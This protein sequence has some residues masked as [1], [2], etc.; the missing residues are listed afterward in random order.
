VVKY[1]NSKET[2]V[3]NNFMKAVLASAVVMASGCA[4]ILNDDVQNVNI[5]SSNG[6]KIQGT[7]NGMPFEGPGIVAVKRSQSDAIIVTNTEGCTPQTAAAS[8]VDMKF[9]IN[10]L[11]G[12]AFGST[13][14]YASEEMWKYEDSIMI[15]CK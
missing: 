10:V 15:N 11:S 14:D 13:T 9:F 7:I 4:T 3:T 5:L 1:D 12:G 6:E 8:S 2:K